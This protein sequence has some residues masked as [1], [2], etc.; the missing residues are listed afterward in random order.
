MKLLRAGLLI[1]V[2]MIASGCSHYPDITGKVVDGATGK[3]IE[4]AL[5]VAQWTKPRGIP[6][7]QYRNLH[8]I[9]EAL[10]DKEGAFS[11]T[12]TFGFN[13]DPPLMLIYKEGYI[14]FRNDFIFP[15][16]KKAEPEWRNNVVYKLEVF[17][18]KYT[19]SQL[20]GFT[21]SAFMIEGLSKVPV[22]NKLHSMLQ[23]YELDKNR[24]EK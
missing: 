22:F 7:M 11:I 16:K 18:N 3:P 1:F 19:V 8:K 6:G 2:L 14:P 4:G 23:N 5:V 13:I 15:V 10:T 12:G 20:V 24:Q 9:T 21:T 17:S